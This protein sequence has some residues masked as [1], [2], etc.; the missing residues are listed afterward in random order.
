MN[1][2]N[3]LDQ[4][5]QCA[6][7]ALAKL[8]ELGVSVNSTNYTIWYSYFAESYPDLQRE[9]DSLLD[10]GTAI[11]EALHETLYAKFF[12]LDQQ[13]AAVRRAMTDLEHLVGR[14]ASFVGQS[15]DKTDGYGKV[16]DD[17]RSR[18]TNEADGG[19]A[20][21][22]DHI[23]RE[24]LQ[25]A[26]AFETIGSGLSQTSGQLAQ[27]EDDLDKMEELAL[28][29]GLTGIANW[30]AFHESLRR[31]A[32]QVAETGGPVSL[33]MIDLDHFTRFNERHSRTLGDKVLAL[34]G[35]ILT[36]RLECPAIAARY[37]GAEFAVILKDTGLSKAVD[38][39][40]A[41]RDTFASH[42]FIK[43][44]SGERFGP[45]TLSIG[46]SE[47]DNEESLAHFIQRTRRAVASAKEQGRNRVVATASQG[48]SPQTLGT[49]AKKRH[50]S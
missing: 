8:V 31:C 12:G 48:D 34:V 44:H 15:Q 30:K 27:L 29:D 18:L 35:R 39:A 4:L 25:V 16:L 41:I 13:G 43:R 7:Q 37:S 33:L 22:I 21:V 10:S 20:E 40:E 2:P 32:I 50:A 1:L 11:S 17:A 23:E 14:V 45:V 36:D 9:I 49:E 24:T 47:Y 28:H 38:Q 42:E 6:K 46:V 5:E 3:E 26:Q 19:V